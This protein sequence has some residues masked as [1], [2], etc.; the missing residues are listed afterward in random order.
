MAKLLVENEKLHKENEHLKQTYKEIFDS[1][2]KTRVLNKDDSDSLISQINQKSIKNADLKAQTQEKVFENAALKNELRKLKGTSV[3][4]KFAKPSILEKPVLQPDRH[5]SVVRQSTAFKSERSKFSK[6]RF[7]SQVDV[8]NDLPKPVTPHYLS[9]AREYALV[10]PHHM[11]APGSSRNRQKESYDTMAEENVLAPAPSRTNEQILPYSAWLHIGKENLLLDLQNAD[12]GKAQ[13]ITLVDSAHPFLSPL[14]SEMGI[15]F[16][17]ELGY[18]EPILFVSKIH[19]NNQHQPWRAIIFLIIQCLTG[20]MSGNDKPRNPVLPESVVHIIGDDFPLGNLKF[21]PKAKEGGKQKIIS[22]AEK[23]EKEKTSKPSPIKKIR[24]DTKVAALV[25]VVSIST[26]SST[27]ADQ[28]APLPKLSSKESS[29]HNVHS[30]NQPPEHITKW[31]KDHPIDNVIRNPFRQVSTR[32]QLLDEAMFCYFDAFL[33]FVEPKTYKDALKESCWIEAMQEELH[34]FE[35][36]R[37]NRQEEGKDFKESFA[38]V[39]RLEAV[40]IFIS[41]AAHMN[42][43]VYQMDVKTR[44]LNGITREEFYVSQPNGFVDEENPNHVYK[45]NKALYG[46]KQ[47]PRAWYDLLS[48]FLLS[49]KFSKGIVDLRLFIKREG[50]EILLVQI[51]VDDIIFAST[52]PDLYESFSDVMCS[53]FKMSM[54]GKL[55]FFLGLQISQCPR[56]IFLNQSKYALELLKNYSMETNEQLNTLMVETSKLDEDPEGK[57]VDPTRYHGMIG[58]LMYLTSSRPD[59]VFDVC[60]SFSEADHAGCQDRRRSTSR[61][62]KL[63][64]ERLIPL[65]CDNKSAIAMCCNNVPHSRSKHI[66]I[67]YHFIK[68]HI[69]NGVVELY[70]VGT[71]YQLA[72]IFTKALPR[73]RLNFL[74][75]KLGMKI[76]SPE[77]LKSL[78]EEDT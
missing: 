5:Q 23:P 13:D 7:A 43:I 65:Y 70:F 26:P 31:T 38:L 45:L 78:A 58:T 18:P 3:D 33:S 77:T 66:G 54:M 17:N 60:M 12:L 11:I 46:L 55:S 35:L 2:K 34:E 62:M 63:L 30:I 49:Q 19:V 42:M 75:E 67:H 61:S 50:K 52:D 73:E 56:G 44:F 76:M 14:T 64:G 15:D 57:A 27:S 51:Y 29:S 72:D 4:T 47:A 74:I 20:K 16:V 24:K 10:K 21:I 32:H 69:K 25:L 39:S 40:R 71:D 6:P 48:S 28:D 36:A 41:F 22:K 53:K 59:L 8:I 68:D 1:I 9:K 37:G